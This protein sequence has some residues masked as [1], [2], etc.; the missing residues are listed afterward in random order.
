MKSLHAFS[1]REKGY[2][3]QCSLPFPVQTLQS[4]LHQG[5]IYLRKWLS[6]TAF[7]LAIEFAKI[8]EFVLQDLV[9]MSSEA[10]AL[11]SFPVVSSADVSLE[12]LWEVD[13]QASVIAAQSSTVWK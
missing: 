11:G 6:L 2:T 13:I 12:R 3:L 4:H 10:G 9:G 8:P 7:P 1:W 5:S